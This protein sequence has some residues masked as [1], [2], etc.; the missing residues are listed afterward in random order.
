MW[1]FFLSV[2]VRG[3]VRPLVSVF[4]SM[5]RVGLASAAGRSPR[6]HRQS[7]QLSHAPAFLRHPPPGAWFGHPHGAGTA[8][9][10]RCADHADLHA[11]RPARSSG[12]EKLFFRDAGRA[13]RSAKDIIFQFD[14]VLQ[15]IKKNTST[16][17]SLEKTSSCSSR[18][19]AQRAIVLAHRAHK[20]N[21]RLTILAGVVTLGRS[22]APGR[23]GERS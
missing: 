14:T 4:S 1:V 18:P 9:P 23:E 11:R 17:V 12:R 15:H 22:R 2:A 20:S 16:P 10:R 13:C 19:M 6:G 8:G 3:F 5:A 21:R 7:C